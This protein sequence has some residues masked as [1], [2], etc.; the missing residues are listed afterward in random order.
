MWAGQLINRPDGDPTVPDSGRE[1]SSQRF[2]LV[3]VQVDVGRQVGRI[4]EAVD[5]AQRRI[6][7][8]LVWRCDG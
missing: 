7:P 6:Q 2:S 1:K 4:T 3:I 5:G 8:G